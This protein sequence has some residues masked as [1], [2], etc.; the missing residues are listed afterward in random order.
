MTR[1]E[2]D[3]SADALARIVHEVG[4]RTPSPREDDDYVG[5]ELEALHRALSVIQAEGLARGRRFC[6]WGS[7]LG[8]GCGVASLNGFDAVGIEIRPDLVA[9]SRALVEDLGLPVV[10]AEGSFLLPGDE[11]LPAAATARTRLRIDSPQWRTVALQ[12]EE[13]DVVFV[14]PWPGE[15]Q[16]IEAVFSRRATSGALL[17]TFHDRGRVLAQ[18]KLVDQAELRV[19]GWL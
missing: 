12:S 17:L 19:I 11:N 2:A 1:L 4:R 14:Y 10:F 13:S 5:C 7:G 8:G 9:S 15:E 3:A 16:F 18:R 6:E